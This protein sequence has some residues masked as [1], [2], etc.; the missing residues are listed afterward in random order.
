MS[1]DDVLSGLTELS[2]ANIDTWYLDVTA[3]DFSTDGGITW[4][5]TAVSFDDVKFVVGFPN[6]TYN[7]WSDDNNLSGDDA[8]QD[9]D[10]DADGFN[11]LYEYGLGGDPN[12]PNDQGMW[13]YGATQDGN[14]FEYVYAKRS[15]PNTDISYELEETDNLPY[16]DFTND[17]PDLVV[18][19]GPIDSE[20][21]AVTNRIETTEAARF[22]RLII[23]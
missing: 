23:E 6:V 15:A 12:D 3:R 11:N 18:S 7:L 8:K 19:E 2:K 20:F 5:N 14:Y 10:P 22:L 9:A 13:E 17:I 16:V 21:N 4:D 1:F